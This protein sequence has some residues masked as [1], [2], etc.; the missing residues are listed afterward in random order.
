MPRATLFLM[1][2]GDKVEKHEVRL[3]EGVAHQVTPRDCML[4]V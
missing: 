2:V 4:K 3:V 1:T